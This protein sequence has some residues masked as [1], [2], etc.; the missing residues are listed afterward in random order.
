MKILT[1]DASTKFLYDPK[2]DDLQ[3]FN[4]LYIVY[5]IVFPNNKMYCGF[6]GNIKNRWKHGIS[7]YKKC[8]FV[9]NAFKKF[10]WDN[11][12]I[13]K[14]IIF[15]SKNKMEALNKEKEIIEELNLLNHNNGYN[16]AKGG[17]APPDNTNKKLNLSSEQIQ[18]KRQIAKKMWEDPQKAA[19][20]KERMSIADKEKAAKMTPEQRKIR[21]GAHNLGRVPPNAKSILQINL[22]TQEILNE[23]SSARQAALNLGLE[24][25]ASSNI[26]RV[27]NGIGKMAYGYGWRWKDENF[28]N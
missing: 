4:N 9:Y 14:Y 28:N 1:I 3:Q 7:A 15:T 11:P 10:G 6:S 18:H 13:K 27:A 23:Y 17:E 20:L 22:E 5:L 19:F 16:L 2:N 25:S 26:R 12:E 21:Y 24:Q 8:P